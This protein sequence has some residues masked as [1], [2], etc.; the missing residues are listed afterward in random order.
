MGT[1]RVRQGEVRIMEVPLDGKETIEITQIQRTMRRTMEIG[2]CK[3]GWVY[4][5]QFF[6]IR[7]SLGVVLTL[8]ISFHPF[9]LTSAILYQ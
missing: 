8:I 3:R 4:E 7:F 2:R 5:S 6:H 9:F 1:H